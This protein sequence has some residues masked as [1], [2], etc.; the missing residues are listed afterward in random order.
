MVNAIGNLFWLIFIASAA[1]LGFIS[2]ELSVRGYLI[3]TYGFY[4]LLYNQAFVFGR[5]ISTEMSATLNTEE[6][7]AFRSYNV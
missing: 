4:A 3:I 1:A 5:V 7:R 6:Q 2:L